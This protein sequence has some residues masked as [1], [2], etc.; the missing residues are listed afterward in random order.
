MQTGF[1]EQDGAFAG[2]SYRCGAVGGGAGVQQGKTGKWSRRWA[3]PCCDGQVDLSSAP[4]NGPSSRTFY[5]KD[6]PCTLL[7]S[8]VGIF[9]QVYFLVLRSGLGEGGKGGGNGNAGAIPA[10]WGK[11]VGRGIAVC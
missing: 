7:G 3:E 6:Y 8:Q 11:A 4:T 10:R 1:S 9:E 5:R 2:Q